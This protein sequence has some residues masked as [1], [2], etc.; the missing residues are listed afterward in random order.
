MFVKGKLHQWNKFLKLFHFTQFS[1]DEIRSVAAN[2]I[3]PKQLFYC[4][5]KGLKRNEK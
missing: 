2:F 1:D 4:N 5:N 3:K